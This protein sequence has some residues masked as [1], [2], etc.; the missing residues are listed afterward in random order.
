MQ[1][2]VID[3]SQ[4]ERALLAMIQKRPPMFIGEYSLS[5]LQ[6][7]F[8]GYNGALR[9]Y[10]MDH[11][12]YRIIPKGFDEFV[13]EKYKLSPCMGYTRIILQHMTDGKE[14]IEVFFQLLDEFLEKNGFDPILVQ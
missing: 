1:D 8:A 4:K 3:I 11:T 12:T 5:K 9:N 6:T 7:F 2:R 13:A 10:A 14:A